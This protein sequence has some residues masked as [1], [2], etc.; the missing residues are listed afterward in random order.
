MNEEEKAVKDGLIKAAFLARKLD[1]IVRDNTDTAGEGLATLLF[2]FC[3]MAENIG[4]SK[5]EQL[6]LFRS[7]QEMVDASMLFAK[8]EAH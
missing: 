6:S 1:H 5:E 2:C 4:V 3:V 8:Q 7:I